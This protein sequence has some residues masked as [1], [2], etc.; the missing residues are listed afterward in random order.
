MSYTDS[1]FF[2]G[3]DNDLQ[4]IHAILMSDS[5]RL[6]TISG[7]GG[8]G[9]TDLVLNFARQFDEAF[10]D[11]IVFVDLQH[12]S[13]PELLIPAILDAMQLK[14]HSNDLAALLS[15]LKEKQVLL[16][17]DNFENLLDAAPTLSNILNTV[18]GVKILVTSRVA[19]RLQEEHIY[20]LMGLS[21]PPENAD[22][23]TIA[24]SSS[25]QLF[26]NKARQVRHD[27]QPDLPD[28]A[29]ICRLVDGNPLAI[30]LAAV[31]AKVLDSGE[32]LRE[33][34]DCVDFLQTDLRN[35]P[36]RHRNIRAV[37]N[38]SWK[39]LGDEAKQ[40]FKRLV[41]FCGSFDRNAAS[42]I[43]DA[44]LMTL[45]ELRDKSLLFVESDGRYRMHALIRQLAYKH[46][47]ESPDE[48]D[49]IHQQHS[50]YYAD[51]SR[52]LGEMLRGKQQLL[53][54]DRLHQD[55][56]NIRIGWFHAVENADANAI[57]KYVFNIA[58]YYLMKSRTQ[59][60]IDILTISEEHLTALPSNIHAQIQL[61][62]GW[63]LII[64]WKNVAGVEATWQAINQ[65][66]NL[67]LWSG[68]TLIPAMNQPE[69]FGE[70]YRVLIEIV[71]STL[72]N[73]TDTWQKAWLHKALGEADFVAGY[74]EPASESFKRSAECFEQIEDAWG[75]TWAYG[76]LGR[77]L[78]NIEKYQ[79]AEQIYLKSIE[80]CRK[81][82]D[83]SGW[84]DVMNKRAELALQQ[85]NYQSTEQLLLRAFQIALE[86]HTAHGT[87]TYV[88][89]TLAKLR[90]RQNRFMEAVSYLTLLQND[91]VV[92]R[93]WRQ[94]EIDML[95]TRLGTIQLEL[96]ESE[97]SASV[98]QG[99]SANL[100]DTVKSLLSNE[101]FP[102][103]ET[104]VISSNLEEPLTERES[105]ILRLIAAGLSN[106]EIASELTLAIGTV[107]THAHNLYGKLG[108]TNR[109]EATARAY[110]LN[111]V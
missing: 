25:V 32:I 71:Q 38:A 45:M 43:A 83:Y 86:Y 89:Y 78:V 42:T 101:P 24:Q 67:P 44:N 14:L 13:K 95:Q 100:L 99:Q 74:Y 23:A 18:S 54:L 64:L 55:I 66:E 16:I 17:L 2:V 49:R 92:H 7:I 68:M 90:I 5:C 53:A 76:N 57:E 36:E 87:F 73:A 65:L 37:F 60:A 28:I 27:F 70:R 97:F 10:S 31:W 33:I 1:S 56:Q 39:L 41:V 110:D 104:D 21:I 51:R 103:I 11:G 34:Q 69:L 63:V 3:R 79:E 6:L 108:V 62:Y 107:K 8:I 88:M 50:Q 109:A 91:P 85:H 98:K 4:Q 20:S 105:Q 30:E 52:S 47:E 22:N 40:I 29:A 106:R 94:P 80:T 48:Y 84:V 26:L 35:V 75:A 61:V 12:I 77:S 59:E 96:T 102:D 15:Y 9:K 81:I 58:L 111:L 46:L 72:E 19:L 82:G 93:G